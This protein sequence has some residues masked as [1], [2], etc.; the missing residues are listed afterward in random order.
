MPIVV[1]EG[2]NGALANNNVVVAL[3]SVVAQAG[4]YLVASFGRNG[5]TGQGTVLGSWVSMAAAG[6][7]NRGVRCMYL[8]CAGGETGNVAFVTLSG[9]D[10]WVIKWWL[11]RGCQ[12]APEAAAYVEQLTTANPNPPSLNPAGWG[13]EDAWWATTCFANGNLTVTTPP[14]NYSNEGAIDGGSNNDI[15]YATRKLNAASD[16]PGTFTLGASVSTHCT[17]IAVRGSTNPVRSYVM[18]I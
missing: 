2:G 18:V 8:I 5:G 11:L 1:A 12:G 4:D 7:N 13:T 10:D 17:T 14:A 9:G 3:G 15:G 6:A 16:D